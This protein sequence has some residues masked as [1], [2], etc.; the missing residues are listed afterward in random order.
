M[1]TFLTVLVTLFVACSG[2]N[3]EGDSSTTPD[4]P[5]ADLET[6]DAATDTTPADA[7]PDVPLVAPVPA[8]CQPNPAPFPVRPAVAEPATLPRLHVQGTDIVDPDGERVALRGVNLGG[9][10][11]IE[12]WM[13]GLGTLSQ[14]E[15]FAAM[16]A[17][18]DA[19]GLGELYRDAR[20]TNYIGCQLLLKPQWVCVTEWRAAMEAAA[21]E[22]ADDVAE[23][24]AWFDGQPWVYEERTF[25]R[26]LEKR[27]GYA[28]MLELRSAWRDNFV[29]ELDFERLEALGLNL[30]RVPV[31]YQ[32]LETDQEGEN[33]F[34]PE[35]WQR[36]DQLMTW[37]RRHHIY[38]MLD[39][40]GAPGGQ[41][42]WWHTGLENAGAFFTTPACQDKAARLWGALARYFK[43]EPHLAAFDLLNEPNGSP[44]KKT[45][46]DVHQKLYDAVRAEDPDHIVVLEDGFV[47]ISKICGPAELGW[48]NG[49]MQFHDYPGGAS[50]AELVANVEGKELEQIRE[51]GERLGAPVFY[52]EF[53]VYPPTDFEQLDDPTDR[54]QLDAMDQLLALF[55]ARGI[56]WAP[57]SWKHFA[58]PSLW[59]VY[60]PA[61]PNQRVDLKDAS[62]EELK[63]AFEG[64]NS[65]TW[66]LDEAYGAVLS[67][68]AKDPV[69]P[70]DL[71]PPTR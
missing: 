54:W 46:C 16:E 56:H 48:T 21:G 32:A 62:L 51:M 45:F 8:D 14:V 69:S 40:H 25:W 67:A 9:W 1:R 49:V 6:V 35:G 59:G 63:A 30:V 20:Q 43:D 34:V 11:M 3:V 5:A 50:A 36:L 15:L 18:A 42:T 33:G 61:T 71:A 65:A 47:P 52:G 29:T 27:F 68:R 23:F 2:N 26:W 57:W 10:L 22:R 58:A 37:A 31:W 24:W 4:Q 19:L 39:M 7:A 53:N 44:N 55:N 66:V 38:V 60:H 41:S 28:G 12:S 64:M 70:L 13:A 17:E